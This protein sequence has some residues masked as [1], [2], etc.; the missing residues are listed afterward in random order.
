MRVTVASATAVATG[1]M[2][3]GRHSNKSS[4]TARSTEASGALKVAA[5]PRRSGEGEVAQM[6]G[7]R[8][9]ARLTGPGRAFRQP[10]SEG[11]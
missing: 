8:P 1:S 4:S 7:A 10:V 2:L 11:D 9:L 6:T 3:R 5:I